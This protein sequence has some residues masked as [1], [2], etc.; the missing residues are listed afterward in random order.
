MERSAMRAARALLPIALVTSC[1]APGSEATGPAPGSVAWY[2][3]ASPQQVANHFRV[4]CVAAGYMPGTPEI[5]E[6]IKRE[7]KAARQPNVARAAA[8]AA[9]TAG[10]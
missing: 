10:N 5:A 7:A 9:A 6:C 8:I 2:E 3:T 1:T 4:Q